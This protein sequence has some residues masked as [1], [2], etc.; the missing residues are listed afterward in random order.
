MITRKLGAALAAGCTVVIKPAEDTP[1]SALAL[2]A[3]AEKAKFPPG[4]INVVPTSRQK[5]PEIGNF[6]CDTPDISV[7]TFTGSTEVGKLLLKRGANTVKR[8]V[9]EL[10]GDAPFIVFD[11][12]DVQKAVEGS[13]V[14]KFRNAGQVTI[15]C[16]TFSLFLSLLTC[17]Y[18][19][20]LRLCKPNI[21][22]R[23]HS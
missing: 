20:D 13:I 15:S 12:A 1:Y 4:V 23:R 16:L 7:I 3:L 17:A 9:M 21:C 8:I 11:S 14:A 6:I 19:L 10:G 18:S 22:A 5:T 2:A